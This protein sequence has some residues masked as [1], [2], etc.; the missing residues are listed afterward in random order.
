MP[1]QNDEKLAFA[2]RLKLALKRSKKK[3]ETATEL[4][5]QFNLRH[6]NDAI[7]PQAAQK[8]LSGKSCPTADKMKTL[9]E[10]LNVSA[11]WLRY[12]IPETKPTSLS[13]TALL[14]PAAERVTLD[15]EELKLITR[16][17]N[18]PE[19]RRKLVC[20]IIEQFAVEQEIWSN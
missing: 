10:W 15:T 3:V 12:G 7:T 14:I 6:P 2:E 20:D 11:Q 5:L 16:L 18:L 9:A 4:A 1:N 19:H 13:K 17:R 8:W